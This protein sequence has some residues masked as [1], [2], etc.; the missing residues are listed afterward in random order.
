MRFNRARRVPAVGI[1]C[2][3][4]VIL[5]GCA[6]RSTSTA[7]DASGTSKLT[8]LESGKSF[9]DVPFYAMMRHGFAERNHLKLDYAQFNS[10]GGSTAQIFAGG[11]GNILAAGIDGVVGIGQQ[12]KLDVTVIGTWTQR[13]YFR[14]VSKAGSPVRTL[15]D[16]RGK[17]VAVSGAGSFSDRALRN[18][19]RQNGMD[20]DKDVKIAGLGGQPQQ[21]AALESGN[22]AAASLNPPTIYTALKAGKVQIVHSYSQDDPMPSIVFTVRTADVRKNP[23]PYANFMKAYTETMQKLKTDPAFASQVA[24]E[25]WGS[26]TPDDVLQ[27]ELKEFLD[28][29]GVWSI[30]GQFTQELYDNGR[31]MLL[32]SGQ[33]QAANFP[34]YQ[35]LTQYAPKF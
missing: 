30:D 8:L 12:G 16:L 27:A 13:N 5:A 31:A 6:S 21:L 3:L 15:Q 20:P 7:P 33:V 14:L 18:L 35:Q 24:K 22:V 23:A 28:D 34:S 19:L 9:Y 25:E 1:A 2:V 10:G 11:T 32:G 17:S 29:P 4:A 26:S